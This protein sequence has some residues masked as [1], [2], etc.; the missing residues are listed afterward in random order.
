MKSKIIAMYLPQFHQIPENDEFWGKGFTD[1]V[2]VKKA[3]PLFQG[4]DQPKVPL[5]N[6]YYDLSVKDSVKWQAELA[7]KFG[8]YGFGIYHYW[9]NNETN[10]LTTP[11]DIIRK[12]SDIDINYYLTWDNANWKRSWSNLYGNA[13]APIIENEK[14]KVGPQILIPYILGTEP[15]WENHYNNVVNHF[16]DDRYIKI[17][18]K[19]VFS[20]LQY[21]DEIFRMCEFWNKLAIRD[22]FDGIYFI[23]KY[24]KLSNI[25][26][27]MHTFTYEPI[28]T[29]WTNLSFPARV[30][31]K[32]CRLASFKPNLKI[33]NYDKIWRRIIANANDCC[34]ANQYFGAFVSYDD[35]PRRGKCGTIVKGS[36]PEKYEYYLRQLLE[37]SERQNKK[38]VFITAW[39][40]WGKEPA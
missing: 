26:P 14:N 13:W 37:I 31:N 16:R 1:W 19:P 12:N 36:S 5:N 30:V 24:N 21:S 27:N 7:K 3:K 22:G 18:N 9:F 15:D 23:Y 17:D 29:G 40:E 25:P 8:V 4:H 6:N 38:F 35:T 34:N 28:Q 39:N 32:I 11:V 33:Y 10:I 20:I 2:T